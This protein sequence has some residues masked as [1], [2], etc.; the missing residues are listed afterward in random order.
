M[1]AKNIKTKDEGDAAFLALGISHLFER[2]YPISYELFS[3]VKAF[4]IKTLP[5]PGWLPS[6]KE[7]VF[8]WGFGL[9]E[10][11]FEKAFKKIAPYL[12]W[13]KIALFSCDL[14]PA[15][16]S[17]QGVFPLSETLS[18]NK[19]LKRAEQSL[20]VVKSLYDGSIAAE[21]YNYYPTGLYEHICRPDFIGRFLEKFDLGLVL[22]LAHAAI[23]AW[24]LKL[25]FTSY[26]KELPLERVVEIHLSR[27]YIPP[28]SGALAVDAHQKPAAREFE[29]LNAALRLL[30]KPDQR[31][32]ITVEYYGDLKELLG[33]YKT[34]SEMIKR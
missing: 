9:V 17:R 19:I 30:P 10:T 23:S 28:K 7:R 31:P 20:A 16:V 5:E 27:P 13:K 14:G 2:S 15:A 11:G 6:I 25:D 21:N 1:N 33:V 18:A 29:W 32:L 4:E 34:V 8:H 12:Q 22:D 24:N 26:L 3:L